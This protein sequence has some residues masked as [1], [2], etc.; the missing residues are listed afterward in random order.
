MTPQCI[1]G[2]RNDECAACRTCPHGLSRARC[3]RC[4]AATA[5]ASRTRIR[6]TEEHPSQVYAGFEIFFD[7]A[8]SGWY[9]RPAEADADSD[10]SRQSY[11]SAFLA[12]KAVDAIADGAK[13]ARSGKRSS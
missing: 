9:Y 12:R 11:R 8:V 3:G 10:A 6:P 4:E 5:A 2:F 13:P 1:H 7:P